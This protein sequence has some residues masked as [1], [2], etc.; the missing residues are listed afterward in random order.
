MDLSETSKKDIAVFIENITLVL[1]SFTLFLLPVFFLINTTDFFV[2]PKQALIIT[3]TILSLILWSVKLILEKKTILISNPF[4]VPLVIFGVIVLLS[5]IFSQNRFDSLIQAVPLL[6]S[7]V[8]FFVI[9]NTISNKKGFNMALSSLVAGTV[10]A[11]LV[12][13]LSFFKIYILP[14]REIQ[15]PVFNTYGSS[16]QEAIFILPILILSLTLILRKIGFPKVKLAG[17]FKGDYS[18]FFH[19][20]TAVVL[21][22]SVVLFVFQVVTSRQKPI[23]LPYAYGFQTAF[24]SIS[25]DATRFIPSLLFG[26][27]YG[28]FVA[29][30]TRFKVQSFNAEN[31]IWNLSFSF[32]SS[33]FLELVA[34]TGILG[35]ASY[36]FLLFKVL[37]SRHKEKNPVFTALIL[38][39]ALSFLLPF[40]F[41]LITELF[42][43]LALYVV[44]L[45]LQKDSKVF[46]FTLSLLSLKRIISDDNLTRSEVRQESAFIAYAIFVISLGVCAFLGYFSFR[47]FMSDMTFAA[48]LKQAAN[49]NGQATYQL[50]A[51]AIGDFPYR[52]DYHR[53]FSQVN[54]AL[55][56]SLVAG[57]KPGE[58]ASP[59]VEKNVLSLLQQSIASARNSVNLSPLLSLNWQNL[60]Q[61]YRNLVGVGQNAESFAIAS[62]NQAITL[63]PYNPQLYIQL[64]GIYYQLKQYEQAQNQFQ[65][66]V[67]L[68]RDFANGYYNLGHAL[69]QKG[70]LENA[71]VSYK[72]VQQLVKQDAEST[73]RISEEVKGLETRIGEVAAAPKT[74][75]ESNTTQ[76][77]L[78][79]NQPQATFPPQKPPVK[80]SPPPAGPQAVEPSASPSVSPTP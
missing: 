22:S 44:F 24:A 16:V 67:N 21:F 32:S 65:I 57:V 40:S 46:D 23:I 72:I 3:A 14:Y 53:I 20:I 78:N 39:F 58:K 37:K 43:I 25:Q 18:F 45:R 27:G 31:A 64:G 38:S 19:L 75:I 70:D 12:S 33:Y 1:I 29:D 49:N 35:A 15:S 47:Y 69:E 74:Q 48:S 59:E 10:A 54:L 56:S 80:I 77:P 52:S 34:T 42:I 51:R 8:L 61:T 4:T 76:T 68:K 79:I 11:A 13:I 36:F 30:F 50:Q 62:F 55:A 26:S 28:T 7:M 2:L 9:A 60:G 17:V 6:C 66:A 73:K 41:V 63:D 71:L 5:A